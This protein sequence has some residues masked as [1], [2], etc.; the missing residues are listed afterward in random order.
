MVNY[1]SKFLPNLANTLAPLY[2]LLQKTKKW[3][4]GAP[5]KTAFIEAKRQLTSQ[6]LLVHFD[7]SKELLL[8]CDASPY[9]IGAVLSHQMPDGT[10]Q[11]IAFTSRSLSKAES[12]YA[13]LDKEG[14]AI[15]YRVKRFHQYLFGRSFKICSDHKP[16]QYIF[17]ETRPIPS[18]ASA[19]LQ[20]WALTLGAYNYQIQYKPGK[21]NSNTDS[22]S[23]LPLPESPSSVPLPGETVFLMDTLDTSPVNATH[24]KT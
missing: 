6:K 7:P 12:N 19:R 14:L 8:S 15:V 3:S 11:P 1:Y 21:D 10:E 17:S 20:R 9:G 5:Q 2:S 13:H 16:L 4:W 23:R 24:I 22:L 18:L